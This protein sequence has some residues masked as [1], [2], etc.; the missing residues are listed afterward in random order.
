MGQE[1]NDLQQ[2]RDCIETLKN[3]YKSQTNDNGSNNLI[4]VQVHSAILH[5]QTAV[6][7]FEE[8]KQG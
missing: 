1:E 4:T 3:V 2:L 6:K 7:Q 8:K 5:I